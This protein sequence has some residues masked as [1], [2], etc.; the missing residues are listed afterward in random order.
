MPD[1]NDDDDDENGENDDSKLLWKRWASEAQKHVLH[2]I[3]FRY[4]KPNSRIVSLWEKKWENM[5]KKF[6]KYY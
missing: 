1:K 5:A 4:G 3:G 2:C 6:A